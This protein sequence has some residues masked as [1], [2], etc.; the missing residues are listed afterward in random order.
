M[1]PDEQA[2]RLTGEPLLAAVSQAMVGLHS[3]PGARTAITGR[4]YLN[5]EMLSCVLR[6]LLTTADRVLMDNG[7][8]PE[9]LFLRESFEAAI[10]E[11]MRSRIEAI[12]GRSV[13]ALFSQSCLR[14]DLTLETFFLSP[15]RA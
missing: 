12:T 4:A 2:Q 5:E 11:R 1:A 7:R 8:E 9:V 15:A 14:P 10:G 6:D 3:E 13:L